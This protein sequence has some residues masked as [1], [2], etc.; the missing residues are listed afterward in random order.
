MKKIKLITLAWLLMTHFFAMP[1]SSNEKVSKVAEGAKLY[2]E[3]CAR[4]HNARP[5]SDYTKR[6]WSVVM[7]HMREKAHMTGTET[8]AVEAFLDSTLTAD[9]KNSRAADVA[10]QPTRSAEELIAQFGC[11]GCHLINGEGG[12]L[13]PTLDGVVQAKGKSFVK[14]KLKN[15]KF[16]NAA[17]A[18]PQFPM[19]SLEIDEIVEFLGQK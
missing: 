14:K 15:P 5:A 10:P 1:V 4:C 17:S 12:N 2:S 7:P 3:N 19:T 11:Q 18:M 9:V 8:L 16:N 13:G 6:E